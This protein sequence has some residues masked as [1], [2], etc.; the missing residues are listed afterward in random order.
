MTN[1]LPV[2]IADALFSSGQQRILALLFGNPDRTYYINEI[3]RLAK[4]GRGALQRELERLAGSGL[5]TVTSLGNQKHFQANR[6][7]P[8]FA[9]LRSLTLKT[10]GLGDVLREALSALGPAIRFAFI[11]GSVAKGIDTAKS[12]IDLMVV[13][14]D[15]DY[16]RLYEVLT[17][18]EETIGR[19]INPTLYSSSDFMKKLDADNHFVTRVLQQPKLMLIGQEHDLPTSRPSETG[20]DRQA[21]G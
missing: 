20:E 4:T 9:E 7:S 19:K 6:A 18:P 1:H 2:T 13:A 8:V 10:F 3:L 21:Q 5:V 16:S 11:Y 15:L 17:T 14:D 12:D